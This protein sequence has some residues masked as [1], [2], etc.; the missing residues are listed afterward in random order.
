M[1]RIDTIRQ[2]HSVREYLDRE[3][4]PETFAQLQTAVDRCAAESGLDIQLIR[5][6]PE[7]F[8]LVARFGLIHG[9]TTNIAFVTRGRERDEEVGYWGQRIVLEAQELGLNTCW[10]AMCARKRSKARRGPDERVRLVIAVG[11]GAHQ[12]K[13]RRT[14]SAEE[15]STVECEQAPEWF[16]TALEAAQLAPTAVNNQN[17]HVVLGADAKTVQITAPEGGLNTVDLGIVKR[18]F[19]EA[20][21]ELGADWRW[22]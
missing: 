15:L 3:I 17:F 5:D 7:V 11:Y 12:G 16:A 19:E 21:N 8:Q 9:A 2:R 1:S 22:A 18:N 4:E 6:N 20:A 13:P 10:V 14:K